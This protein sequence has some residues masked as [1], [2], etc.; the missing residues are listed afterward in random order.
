MFIIIDTR[1]MKVTLDK[2]TFFNN[3]GGLYKT[4]M[5]EMP[6]KYRY[7]DKIAIPDFGLSLANF[8]NVSFRGKNEGQVLLRCVDTINCAYSGKPM[9]SQNNL[10][11]A[12]SKLIKTY[13]ADSAIKV[14]N[15]YTK[16]MYD[17]ESQVFEI[18]KSARNKDKRNFSDILSEYAPASLQ[19]L[20]VKQRK[21]LAEIRPQI[22]HLS[23]ELKERA[24]IILDDLFVRVNDGTFNRRYPAEQFSTLKGNGADNEVLSEINR[25]CYQ[26][27]RSSKDL[28]AFIVRYS[29]SSHDAIARRLL[30]PA[31]ATIEHIIPQS[32]NGADDM[33]NFLLVSAQFN[34]DRHDLPLDE[35]IIL[36]SDIDIPAHLQEY[37]DTV[38]SEVM[39]KNS[40]F[41]SKKWYPR[42][43]QRTL[44]QESSGQVALDMGVLNNS[45]KHV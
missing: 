19:R 45:K 22:E 12:F 32:K 42:A 8:P 4:N 38:V 10:A 26:L 29:K 27:P 7:P 11:K 35:F 3:T 23:P 25:I 20:R 15:G 2:L 36:N 30:S 14:L 34:N 28:D 13:D 33:S 6:E 21:V 41:S 43:I 31:A 40:P 24:D 17:V 44:M 37:M 9:I 1:D 16:Y 5:P 39:R 18:L